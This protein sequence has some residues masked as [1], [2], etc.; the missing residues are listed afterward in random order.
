MVAR[1]RCL[2]ATRH[3]SSAERPRAPASHARVAGCS[4]PGTRRDSAASAARRRAPARS[5][6]APSSGSRSR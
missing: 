2:G 1:P 3:A 4:S 5:K 6:Y